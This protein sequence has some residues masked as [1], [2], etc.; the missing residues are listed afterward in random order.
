MSS[1]EPFGKFAHDS[2]PVILN[3]VKDLPLSQWSR[4]LIRVIEASQVGS[5]AVGSG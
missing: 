4:G 3:G 5:L 2:D 1:D